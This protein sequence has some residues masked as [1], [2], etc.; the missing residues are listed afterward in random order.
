MSH[1]QAFLGDTTVATESDHTLT[2]NESPE[3]YPQLRDQ[4]T[5]TP[6]IHQGLISVE[7][8][9]A[10]RF[11]QG[12]VTCD[13]FR[14]ETGEAQPG[15]CCTP[16]GR[17]IASFW[18]HR[19]GEQRFLMQMHH[20]LVAPTLQHLEKYAAF[21]K[22]SLAEA[23]NQYPLIGLS[24]N[25]KDDVVESL[26]PFAMHEL[27]DGRKIVIVEAE[28][29]ETFWQKLT[30]QAQPVGTEYWQW[31][32]IVAGLGHVQRE[33]SD[34]F[35]PQMLNLQALDAISFKKGC[36]T[37]QEVVARMKYLGKLKRHMYR[38]SASAVVPLPAPG[39]PCALPDT[40]QSAGNLV[41]I[42]RTG[43]NVEM[44]AVLTDQAAASDA[45]KIG[46]HNLPVHQLEL[47]YDL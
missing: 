20:S 16:K 2:F 34:L 9:D 38:L 25:I 32:D 40:E 43:K 26:S 35:I 47:P 15:A 37:G 22:T 27:P 46:E 14:L 8:A 12:Q 24:S 4:T 13:V 7:G 6:L 39:S 23:T 21:F 31:L 42:A 30:D 28:A 18:L 5:A 41:S 33:T 1:W 29:A 3:D 17:M 45:L 36:Y 19:V 44:L 11:L 10:C